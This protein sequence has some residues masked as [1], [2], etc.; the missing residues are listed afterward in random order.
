MEVADK[1]EN[2]KYKKF[3]KLPTQMTLRDS[4]IIAIQ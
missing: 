3:N 2:T 4:S 1:S